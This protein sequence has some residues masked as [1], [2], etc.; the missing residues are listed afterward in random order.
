MLR[1]SV[2]AVN[3]TAGPNGLTPSELVLD[4][5]SPF[6]VALK[7]NPA[8]SGHPRALQAARNEMARITAENRVTDSLRQ[9]FPPA[10]CYLLRPGDSVWVYREATRS[11]DDPFT[12]TQVDRK[13]LTVSDGIKDKD[14]Q[15]K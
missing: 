2:E 4:V 14:I 10:S 15:W 5:R 11:C 8:Q 1:L 12:V 3:N 7:T 9:K 13:L 6:P